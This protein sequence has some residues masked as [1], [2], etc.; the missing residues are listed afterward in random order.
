ME[1][2]HFDY[3]LIFFFKLNVLSIF[4]VAAAESP[5]VMF[6]LFDTVL[7]FCDSAIPIHKIKKRDDPPWDLHAS[8]AQGQF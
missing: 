8:L 7:S 1:C 4:V 5:Q 6:L 3:V 2:Q